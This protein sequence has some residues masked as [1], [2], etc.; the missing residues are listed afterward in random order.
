M[1]LWCDSLA[2]LAI[3]ENCVVCVP[4]GVRKQVAGLFGTYPVEA[5]IQKELDELIKACI[6]TEDSNSYIAHQDICGESA[7]GPV[8]KMHTAGD[9]LQVRRIRTVLCRERR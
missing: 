9:D 8:H 1:R 7:Q 5:Y 3:V 6:Y 2:T 4:G